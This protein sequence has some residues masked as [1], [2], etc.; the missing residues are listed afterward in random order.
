MD[1]VAEWT[2]HNPDMQVSS[3]SAGRRVIVVPVCP[4]QLRMPRRKS[5]S[6]PRSGPRTCATFSPHQGR[7]LCY[8][9]VQRETTRGALGYAAEGSGARDADERD[10]HL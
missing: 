4:Q 6:G 7:A 9:T 5:R 8:A 2:G 10:V 1:A 3:A